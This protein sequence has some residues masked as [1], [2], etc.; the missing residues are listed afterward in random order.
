MIWYYENENGKVGPIEEQVILHLA[1]DGVISHDTNV[2]REDMVTWRPAGETGLAEYFRNPIVQVLPPLKQKISSA[3]VAQAI[4]GSQSLAAP[5]YPSLRS[6][7][8]DNRSDLIY[9]PTPARSPHFA[10]ATFFLPGFAHFIFGQTAKSLFL[11]MISIFFLIP[12]FGLIVF[13]VFIDGY[14]VGNTLRSGKPVGRWE[15]FPK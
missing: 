14:M 7:H 13:L 8:Q 9:P 1:A 6:T 4:N 2:W 15:F 11:F 10:W 3:K 12:S 5:F